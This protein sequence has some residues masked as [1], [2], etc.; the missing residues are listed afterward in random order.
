MTVVGGFL[1]FVESVGVAYPDTVVQFGAWFPDDAAYLDYLTC[2]RWGD[3]GFGCYLCGSVGRGW[4]RGDG[5][6]WACGACSSRTSA[7]AGTIFHRTRT[8]LTVWFR[9][10]WELTT[11][12]NGVSARGIQRTLGLGSYQTAWTMLHRYRRAM[13]MPGRAKLSGVVEV[14]DMFVGGRNK[15]GMAGRSKRP[16]K[17]PVLMMAE[18][19][20]PRGIGRCRAVVLPGLDGASLRSALRENIE[21]GSV[22]RSDGLI[23]LGQ[24][25]DGLVQ[26]RVSVRGSGTP[27]HV[28]F[29]VVPR[30]QSQAKRWL[31]GTLQGAAEPEHLQEYLNEFEFRFNRRRAASPGCCSTDCSNKPSAPTQP[32]MPTS[33]S[34][35][36]DRAR[37]LRCRRPDRADSRK[38]G[39]TRRRAPPGARSAAEITAVTWRGH[40]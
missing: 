25:M 7:T 15:P 28:L 22:V 17:T 8:P 9:A 16:H 1:G 3:A 31:E 19:R 24:S 27:A 12:A 14:G 5:V 40:T 2:L 21:P 35:A 13:V 36:P 29:P 34:A 26:D 39:A 6:G 38:P 33:R 23:V 32:D 30:V 18:V 10:G 4:L 20:S 11:R 37:R